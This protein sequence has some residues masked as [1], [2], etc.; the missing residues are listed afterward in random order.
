MDQQPQSSIKKPS[1]FS[2][3]VRFIFGRCGGKSVEKTVVQSTVVPAGTSDDDITP[4]IFAKDDVRYVEENKPEV[5]LVSPPNSPVLSPINRTLKQVPAYE[6]SILK[7]QVLRKVESLPQRHTHTVTE[8]V[9]SKVEN[10]EEANSAKNLEYKTRKDADEPLMNVGYKTRKEVDEPTTDV[11]HKTRMDVDDPTTDV[12]HKTMNDMEEL[13]LVKDV[14]EMKSKLNGLESKLKL[15]GLESKLSEAEVIISKE[16]ESLQ[17]ELVTEDVESK[18]EN[19]EEANSA[20]NLEYKTRKDADEPLMNVGYK[21]RKEVD[22]PTTDVEHKTRMDVDGPTTDVEHKTM[23]DMEEL[24]LVKDVSEMK[25]KLNGLESKLKLN[26]LESKLSE[27]EAI[28][29]KLTEERRLNGE[30]LEIHPRE[31]KFIFELKKQ[32]TCSVRLFNKSNNHVAFKVKAT[33]PKKYS[34][35]PNIG[36][37]KPK[38]TCEFTVKMQAQRVAPPDMICKDMFLVQ[39]TVVPAGTSDDDI[40]RS[41]FAKDDVRYV[42][43]NKLKV[44]LVSPPDSPVLSPINRTLKQV[45]AYEPSILK[46][47]VLRKVESLTQR[48]TVTEDVESKVENSEE[49]NSAKNLEYKTRK[50]ADEP[51]MNVGYKTRKEVDEPTTDVEH[52]TR[53]DVDGPTTDVE[54]KTMNDMEELKLVKDVSEM[55]SELNG[56]ESKLS[57]AEVIISKGRKSLQQELTLLMSKRLVSVMKNVWEI[58]YIT[59]GC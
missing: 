14:S 4:S 44:V 48:H 25:S 20:K 35:R 39:S 13:K 36:I 18:V 16:R 53:M 19:S 15:N 59:R 31:L 38:S 54:H 58:G 7:D 41:I 2:R 49:A 23:N 55:K 5:V 40:T 56:L 8:D 30:L 21:T 22:E 10:S 37:I 3:L 32:S 57:E 43:E 28:I 50:D 47:Q 9:E 27:A 46:D 29:S 12:E 6:P 34:V 51:L 52:K 17:Q 45:P 33:S 11:E 42:E 26:G 1:K 24:K